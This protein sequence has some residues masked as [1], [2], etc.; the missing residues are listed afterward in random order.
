MDEFRHLHT[1]SLEGSES[2]KKKKVKKTHTR[3][4][5][6]LLTSCNDTKV[7]PTIESSPCHCTISPDSK[8]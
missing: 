8:K 3:L 1:P 4:H 6:F 2:Y 5:V 7:M